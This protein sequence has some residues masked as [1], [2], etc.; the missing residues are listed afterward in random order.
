MKQTKITKSAKGEDCAIRIP[1][2]CNRDN[3]TTI[4]AH[5]SGVRFGHGMAHKVDNIFGAYSCSKCHDL[6][7]GRTNSKEFTE[8]EIRLMH[9]DGVIETQM[10]LIEKGLI[11]I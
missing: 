1:N 6:I 9:M 7:D 5:L 8:D 2:V 10:R 11:K 3:E 4:F